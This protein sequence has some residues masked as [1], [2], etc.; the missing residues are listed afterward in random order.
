MPDDPVLSE[1]QCLF[2]GEIHK[3]DGKAEEKCPK[4]G[5]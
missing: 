3:G 5:K 1:W 4:C 2:C